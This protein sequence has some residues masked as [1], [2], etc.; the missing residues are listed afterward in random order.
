MSGE[1][2]QPAP[3]KYAGSGRLRRMYYY[4]LMHGDLL[5]AD[6]TINSIGAGCN[7]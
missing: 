1:D 7:K 2:V 3:C 4:Y 5:E 6:S